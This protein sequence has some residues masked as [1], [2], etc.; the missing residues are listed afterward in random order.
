MPLDAIISQ[1]GIGSTKVKPFV[2]PTEDLA[3]APTPDFDI[4]EIT[5][6]KSFANN[7]KSSYL[8]T[9]VFCDLKLQYP[10]E[11]IDLYFN[12]VIFDINNS[13]NIVKTVI[14]DRA[15]TVK[16]FVSD[17]DYEME[18]KIIISSETHNYPE[19]AVKDLIQ[20]CKLPDA[21][22]CVSPLLQLFDIDSLVI[23][24]YNI[25]PTQGFEN[26]QAFALTC[27]SDYPIELI[28]DDQTIS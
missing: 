27:S 17:G 21:I 6:R 8:G 9:H 3:S 11:K 22:E 15:G 23:D 7:P 28:E 12:A 1:F 16:E 20:L 2:P 14:P 24:S 26:D 19:D 10:D 4:P 5:E 18:I 13:K 25:L